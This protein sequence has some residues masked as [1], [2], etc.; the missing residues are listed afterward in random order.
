[1]VATTVALAMTFFRLFDIPVFWPVLVVY[2]CVL[3]FLT[4]KRQIM[5]RGLP[6]E[7]EG[8]APYD[9]TQTHHITSCTTRHATRCMSLLFMCSLST[10]DA[11]PLLPPL[12]DA[13]PLPPPL[14]AHDQVP[15]PPV[16]SRQETV[17]RQGGHGEGGLQLASHP[18]L[19]R[20]PQITAT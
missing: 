20:P 3:F 15:V 4:M 9:T 2:F 16:H 14:T 17:P 8:P 12:T 6:S 10:N 11:P 1:M 19:P 18:A 7:G 13:P 5:V